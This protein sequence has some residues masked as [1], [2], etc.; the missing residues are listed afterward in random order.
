MK[1]FLEEVLD[2]L[3]IEQKIDLA[4]TSFILPSKRAGNALKE[5]LKQ[6][7]SGTIFSPEVWS[8]EE[9]LNEVTQL[10]ELDNTQSIFSFY[11]VYK[12]LTPPKE[13]EDFETFYGWAQTL[14]HDFNEIDRHLIEVDNFFSYLSD[15]QEINHWSTQDNQTELIKN[16]LRFWRQ[17]PIYYKHFTQQILKAG[18]AYQGLQYRKAAET[19]SKFL[20]TTDKNY[21]FLGFNALNKAEQEI[22][23]NVLAAKKG[24]VFWDIDKSFFENQNHQA[25]LFI[26]DYKKNW[27]YY[28]QEK[29]SL[30]QLSNNYSQPKSI[31]TYAVSQNIG[32]AKKIG[33]ILSKFSLEEL[34]KTAVVLND[35]TLLLPIL[36]SLPK[37]VEKVNITM[38][39]PLKDTP[40]A[41]FFEVL[42]NIQRE[43]QKKIYYKHVLEV[44]NHPFFMQK[45]GDTGWQTRARIMQ[46][47]LVFISLEELLELTEDKTSHLLKLCFS[48][49]DKNPINFLRALKKISFA[50]RV[51]DVENF[52]LETEYLFHF[53]KLFSKLINLL[54]DKNSLTNINA[55]HRIYND[56][57]TS[58]NLDFS[59]SPF[60][61][62]QLMGMLESRVLD[63]ENVIISSVNE[64]ILPAGKSTN[65]FIPY[66]LKKAYKLPTYKEKDAVYTYHFYHLL[67]RAKNVFLLYNSD[68]NSTNGGEKSRFI[69]QLEIEREVK[70]ISVSP[71]VPAIK[72][73]LKEIEKTPEV[74]EKIKSIAKSGFSPSALTT[75]IRNPLD[76]YKQYILDIKDSPEVE[77]T[78]AYNTLGSIVHD[79]LEKLF[80]PLENQK[81]SVAHVKQMLQTY[82]DRVQLEFANNYKQA[83][84][85]SGK[86]LLIYEVANR[87]VK[88]FLSNQLH[89]LENNN[90]IEILIIEET[91]KKNL[92]IE[93][94]NFPVN[95]KGKVDRVDRLN[96]MLRVVDYKTGMVTAKNLKVTNWENLITDYDNSKAFQ[97]LTYA[98]LIQDK[99]PDNKF[100][101]GIISLRKMKEGF[102][103][104]KNN[105]TT[106]INAETLT[107]YENAVKELITEIANPQIPFIEKE[108]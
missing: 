24:D 22:I 70:N 31:K 75:Y 9:F 28:A 14:I 10:S 67:Q 8:I 30:K 53:H 38:G 77:E 42:F 51:D 69:T 48:K 6:K 47:N 17:L 34:K 26:R 40:L 25:G 107:L 15:I 90:D 18:T 108:V 81:L 74:L 91:H 3:I 59:G 33:D 102:F 5:H 46:E 32:Q 103:H 93:K 49:Y 97:V 35:E 76:F 99:L 7:V 13:T 37:N 27:P 36:N 56:L 86:N 78:V 54:Q 55:L 19:I 41:S 20:N 89:D 85:N 94:L 92:P 44:I 95:L 12:K 23:Q 61:G 43:Q 4:Q 68:H 72:Q 105:N 79:S 29:Q 50:L 52:R 58:E 101:A 16:Y 11:E 106:I 1:A 98:Y 71:Q 2:Y 82:K 66:D 73:S 60:S 104:F 88:N 64:G 96:G 100:E 45:I 63:F 21:I 62:L 87:Y 57:L 80:K 84:I 83:P 65:S 39:L